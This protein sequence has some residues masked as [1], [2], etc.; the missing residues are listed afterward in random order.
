VEA[1]AKVLLGVAAAIA[2][3]GVGLLI[4]AKLGWSGRLPGTISLHRGSWTVYV[5]IGLSIALSL[6]L[7]ILLNVF[8]RR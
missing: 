7:T 3:V 8:L 2:V 5:P 4:A 1:L 6:L